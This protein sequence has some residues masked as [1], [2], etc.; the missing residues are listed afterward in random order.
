MQVQQKLQN[1]K[2]LAFTNGYTELLEYLDNIEIT[3]T[4]YG[5][6]IQS[7]WYERKMVECADIEDTAAAMDCTY[8]AYPEAI[9]KIKAIEN[10]FKLVVKQGRKCGMKFE[11]SDV[12][13]GRFK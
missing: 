9:K 3:E 11:R 6:D 13:L 7:P 2:F 8:T 5:H 1:T 4:S 10:S 12:W